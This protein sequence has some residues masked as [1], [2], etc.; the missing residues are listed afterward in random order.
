MIKLLLFVLSFAIS[1]HGAPVKKKIKKTAIKPSVT[2]A[3][4]EVKKA[5][6]PPP[7]AP[8]LEPKIEPSTPSI[9]KKV[10]NEERTQ[11][12]W[13]GI[14]SYDWW[15]ETFDLKNPR[16]EAFTLRSNTNGPCIG[17]GYL[18]RYVSY[19]IDYSACG[20]FGTSDVAAAKSTPT[21]SQRNVPTYGGFLGAGF[22]YKPRNGRVRFGLQPAAM[23]RYA[24]W[25]VP[26]GWAIDSKMRVT[27]GGF[28]QAD[29]RLNN[30]F[31][32]EKTG[33]FASVGWVWS[34]GLSIMY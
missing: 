32:T 19:D 33:Y 8:A 31:I 11:S 6:E 2:K 28:L 14:L 9:A 10:R 1:A 3:A 12:R 16:G 29:W 34:L 22:Y 25:T 27:G 4:P 23:V 20:F 30:V 17:L 13:I 24:E 5:P 7:P 15:G 26:N 21:Y 18:K